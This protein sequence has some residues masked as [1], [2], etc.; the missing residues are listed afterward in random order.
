MSMGCHA[1]T[2]D[3]NR[4][5]GSGG[6]QGTPSVEVSQLLPFRRGPLRKVWSAALSPTKTDLTG[7]LRNVFDV[8]RVYDC[9]PNG[10]RM[11]SSY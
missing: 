10:M 8:G 5:L 1:A 2:D 7:G 9:C 3:P 6:S 11:P 4:L